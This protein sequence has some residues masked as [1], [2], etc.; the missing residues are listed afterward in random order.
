[1]QQSAARLVV[2]FSS[3]TVRNRSLG[4]HERS[5]VARLRSDCPACPLRAPT[6]RCAASALA[7]GRTSIDASSSIGQLPSDDHEGT[8]RTRSHMK[9]VPESS[10]RNGHSA[11]HNGAAASINGAFSAT[12]HTYVSGVETSRAVASQASSTSKMSA[13]DRLELDLDR[14]RS[15][16]SSSRLEASEDI[17]NLASDPLAR[18]RGAEVSSERLP[19][20]G[21]PSE[22][23][24][25]P[26]RKR[27]KGLRECPDS[28]LDEKERLRRMRISAANKGKKPWND[29][30][31]HKPGKRASLQLDACKGS[32]LL[33]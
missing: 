14:E 22:A 1:M 29:G 23:Q 25:V 27:L 12:T 6:L 21:S 2:C 3:L 8:L 11:S 4:Q 26:P 16:S 32:K 28:S 31:R 30:V 13:Q 24:Y 19:D 17:T 15:L 5:A 7:Q 9:V 33:K 18:G 10:Y 20:M